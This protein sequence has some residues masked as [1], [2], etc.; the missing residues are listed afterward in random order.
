MESQTEVLLSTRWWMRSWI[1]AVS[2]WSCWAATW[3]TLTTHAW[4]SW[5]SF[6]F[7][8]RSVL[9]LGQQ[10]LCSQFFLFFFLTERLQ[11]CIPEVNCWSICVLQ[12][13]VAVMFNCVLC[14]CVCVLM[15]GL[16]GWGCVFF[17]GGA[18]F[19]L[20][21]ILYELVLEINVNNLINAPHLIQNKKKSVVGVSPNSG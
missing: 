17:G 15:V 1:T 7:W 20:L 18:P 16:L 11:A 5:S 19:F 21:F 4:R 3:T 14:V 2:W 9:E 6:S 12:W 13:I 8:W 10:R